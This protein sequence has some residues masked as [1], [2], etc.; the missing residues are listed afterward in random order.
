LAFTRRTGDFV[1]NVKRPP[2]GASCTVLLP[3]AGGHQRDLN[4]PGWQRLR[5]HFDSGG[6]ALVTMADLQ[7]RQL[8]PITQAWK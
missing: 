2:S 5:A 7:P 4:G 6:S 3:S 8:V 1:S